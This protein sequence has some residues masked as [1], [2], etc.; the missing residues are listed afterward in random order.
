MTR[1]MLTAQKDNDG[2]G[3]F[4]SGSGKGLQFW[5]NGRNEGFDSLMGIGAKSGKGAVIMINANDDSR[6]L[7]KIMKAIAAEYRWRDAE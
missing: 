3:V 6:A 2:L 7:N 4:L 1:Q 5:H